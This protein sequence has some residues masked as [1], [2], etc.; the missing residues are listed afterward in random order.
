MTAVETKLITEPSLSSPNTAITRPTS[1]VR[2]AMLPG[3]L[4]S[5]PASASTLRLDNAIALVS[6]VVIST[7]RA[8]SAPTTVGAIPE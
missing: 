2:V 6:V 3:S 8:N 1:S 7:V 5:S 4:G